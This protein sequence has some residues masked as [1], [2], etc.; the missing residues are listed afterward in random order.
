MMNTSIKCLVTGGAGFIGS[1]LC[2]VLIDKGYE[3]FCIDNLITGSKNNIIHLL[4]NPRFHFI[5]RDIIKPFSS[6]IN[7]QLSTI[8]YLYH[9][10]SPASPPQY[11]KYS[12]E[13]MLVNS[14]GTYN[15][16]ELAKKGNSVFLL[17]STS[18]VYGNPLTHPQKENYYG[19]VNPT[20]MRACYDE[21]KRFAEAITMEYVRKFKL[22]GR[23]VRIFNTYGPRMQ[24]TDGRVVSNFVTQAIGGKP[25]TMYGDG[26]QTRSFCYISDMV[27]GLVAAGEKK[28]ING[29]VINLGNPQELTI[30]RIGEIILSLVGSS[31]QLVSSKK[32]EIDDPQMRKPDIS[33]AKQLLG[34]QPSVSL[35]LGLKETIKYFKNL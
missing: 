32:K 28:G 12:I 11:R 14:L 21:S 18:E 25:L 35:D 22:Q 1:H 20:G 23:I 10:A 4:N 17:A 24:P 8:N 19:N 15:M 26:N 33:K 16:L 5:L 2:D 13:T 34:W 31:S 29:E 9:L 27:S 3:V 30:K 7:H 6:N